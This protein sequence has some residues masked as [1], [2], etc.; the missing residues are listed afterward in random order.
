MIDDVRQE[1]GLSQQE[2][3]TYLGIPRSTYTMFESGK[4]SLPTAANA[5]LVEAYAFLH[6]RK[7]RL[8]ARPND[9]VLPVAA[10]NK[11]SIHFFNNLIS[12]NKFQIQNA[13][14]TLKK[15]QEQYEAHC[16]TLEL[17]AASSIPAEPTIQSLGAKVIA[18][19]LRRDLKQYDLNAQLRLEF[20]I[21]VMEKEV[22]LAKEM[23]GRLGGEVK[24]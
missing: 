2:M 7:I 5:V 24:E 19:I 14:P 1:L 23:V 18:S 10:D 4:R 8:A 11:D 3:A 17:I 13:Q 16:K 9:A 21:R 22:E 12:N 20:K 15:L 6:Q